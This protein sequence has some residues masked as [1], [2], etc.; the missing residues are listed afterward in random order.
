M[1]VLSDF[2][3]HWFYDLQKGQWGYCDPDC[4]QV[5][6]KTFLSQPDPIVT[7]P[8]TQ[9]DPIE[10][11]PSTENYDGTILPTPTDAI[12]NCGSGVTF[13]S[14]VGGHDAK[15]GAYPFIAA[16]GY[17]NAKNNANELPI[18]FACGG[19][20]I[21]R[22]YVLTAGA[23]AIDFLFVI[24]PMVATGKVH[25]VCPWLAFLSSFNSSMLKMGNT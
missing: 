23:N 25:E 5:G 12:N 1:R 8:S 16:L 13:G 4:V 17:K 7:E 19:S 11:E 9:P 24:D 20:L 22:R 10:T 6:E 21:N 15:K 18:I 2:I 3:S 14:I